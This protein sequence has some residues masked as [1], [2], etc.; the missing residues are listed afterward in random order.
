MCMTL[1]YGLTEHDYVQHLLF[2]ATKSDRIKKK[3]RR[4]WIK[5]TAVVFGFG[6][7]FYLVNDIHM[8]YYCLVAGFITLIFY[9][10][11]ERYHYRKHY[12][13]F[14]ADAYKNRINIIAKVVLTEN[15]IETS[16]KTGEA[17]LN[18]SELQEIIETNEYF[19]MNL[20]VGESLIIPKLKIESLEELRFELKSL[21]A[22]LNINFANDL[23][24]HWK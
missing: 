1:K 6:L 10:S 4:N 13:K 7:I 19:Y 22:K 11:Y 23:S 20:K 12:K 14:V 18:L 15:T 24:W 16:D 21:A 8:F 9:P 3:R 5:T 17:K 2:T